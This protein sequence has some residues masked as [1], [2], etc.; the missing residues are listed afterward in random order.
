MDFFLFFCFDRLIL[1][2]KIGKFKNLK[3]SFLGVILILRNTKIGTNMLPSLP[4]TRFGR[5]VYMN[6]NIIQT[7]P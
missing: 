5:T 7:H 4:M 1:G 3:I 6:R 2:S